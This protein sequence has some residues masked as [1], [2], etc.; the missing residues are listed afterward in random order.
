MARLRQKLARFQKFARRTGSEEFGWFSSLYSLCIKKSL[1]IE[2]SF[3]SESDEGLIH[4]ELSTISSASSE[5]TDN[6]WLDVQ[7]TSIKIHKIVVT[8]SK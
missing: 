6:G 8:K 2:S 7:W 1:G 5:L 3:D 4:I